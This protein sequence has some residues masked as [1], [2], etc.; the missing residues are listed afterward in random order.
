MI[1]STIDGCEVTKSGIHWHTSVQVLSPL[2]PADFAKARGSMWPPPAGSRPASRRR[3]WAPSAVV[4]DVPFA[5]GGLRRLAR[6]EVV[7]PGRPSRPGAWSS[8]QPMSVARRRV[9]LGFSPLAGAAH[10]CKEAFLRFFPFGPRPPLLPRA[11]PPGLSGW[12]TPGCAESRP[13]PRPR[14]RR[15]LLF[16]ASSR[17]TRARSRPSSGDSTHSSASSRVFRRRAARRLAVAICWSS[18]S[19]S[20][21]GPTLR[22]CFF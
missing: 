5:A 9:P 19:S 6:S 15:T 2:A 16:L 22:T 12:G 20:C 21:W 18:R 11:L 8:R 4:G 13:R 14:S 10:G 3:P 1:S 7:H 17:S